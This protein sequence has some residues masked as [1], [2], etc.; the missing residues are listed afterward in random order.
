MDNLIIGVEIK[1]LRNQIQYH[2]ITGLVDSCI[3]LSK[4]AMILN[5]LPCYSVTTLI[6][7]QNLLYLLSNMECN[8]SCTIQINPSCNQKRKFTKLMKS[9]TNIS[10]TQGMQKSTKTRNTPTYFIHIL[11]HIMP[12]I[13]LKDTP[14]HKQI[15]S[16]MV[17]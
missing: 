7:Q 15:I 1:K 10:S 2:S 5:I 17:P 12:H 14:S 16:S 9:R 8:V 6:S 13:Y 11:M 4:T 3:S